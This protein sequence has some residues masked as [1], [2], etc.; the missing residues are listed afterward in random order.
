MLFTLHGIVLNITKLV[1]AMLNSLKAKL[2]LG[3]LSFRLSQRDFFV[4]M[5]VLT[6]PQA[7][8]LLS[9]VPIL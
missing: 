9:T 2:L 5:Q 7:P 1:E 6:L 8:C 3:Q 4:S